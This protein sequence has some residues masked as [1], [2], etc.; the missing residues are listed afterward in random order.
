MCFFYGVRA[1]SCPP[2][3][4]QP[5]FPVAYKNSDGH[6]H[7]A[8]GTAHRHGPDHDSPKSQHS[9]C[10]IQS[11][12]QN[13][14]VSSVQLIDVPFLENRSAHKPDPGT[15]ASSF[16]DASPF[17]HRAPPW[18]K[19]LRY[20]SQLIVE[21]F[22]LRPWRV[23]NVPIDFSEVGDCHEHTVYAT[24]A[25]IAVFC[26]VLPACSTDLRSPDTNRGSAPLNFGPEQRLG[27]NEKNPST[28]FLR[29][30]PDGRLFA[31]W[32]E[33]HDA[34]GPEGSQ[35]LYASTSIRR[36]GASPMRNAILAWSAD[37][38]KT[39][40]SPW[41]VNS[42]VEA[43]QGEENGP[44]VA[45]A[46]NKAYVVWSIPGEKGRQNARQYPVRDGQWERSLHSGA[47]SE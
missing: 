22:V 29:Y 6:V 4:E 39:W 7:D 38:G 8:A 42:V 25:A 24:F 26:F 14:H 40:S 17:S 47:D 5:Q 36:Q 13:S 18:H 2:F 3:F 37:G 19:P 45:F 23:A 15:V 27:D 21:T 43:V 33:D 44:K 32:T 34:P 10:A 28:P 12:A 30:S 35:T 16:F 20:F 1:P 11:V 46:D 41:R 31:V 9:D